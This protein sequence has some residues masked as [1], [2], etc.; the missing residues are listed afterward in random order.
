MNG[1]PPDLYAEFAKPRDDVLAVE[2]EVKCIVADLLRLDADPDDRIGIRVDKAC[3]WLTDALRD[4]KWAAIAFESAAGLEADRL[5]DR[6]RD[7]F[8]EAGRVAAVEE[9]PA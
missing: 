4:F 9:A 7:E 2:D 8:E 1:G 3:R 6:L 5:A